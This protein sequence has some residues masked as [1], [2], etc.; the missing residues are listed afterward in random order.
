MTTNDPDRAPF[1]PIS[2]PHGALDMLDRWRQGH[3]LESV[4]L[5]S[6][7]PT[8][9]YLWPHA[10]TV[11]SLSS[12]DILAEGP[13]SVRHAMV[14]SQGCDLVKPT[15]PLATV[16][17]VYDG[18]ATLNPAQQS[19]ARAGSTWHLVHL[20][21]EWAR[22]GFWVADLRIEMS[23]DKS[24]LLRGNPVEGFADGADYAILAERLAAVRMRPA[25]PDPTIDWV[26]KPLQEGLRSARSAGTEM[27]DGVREVRLQSN[28]PT[29]PTVVTVYVVTDDDELQAEQ[30]WTE[31]VLSLSGP[32]DGAGLTVV[33]PEFGTLWDITAADYL[34]SQA[35]ESGLSS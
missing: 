24:L 26:M 23:V 10:R 3:I 31:L 25:M 35:M 12:V 5:V 33:G 27:L 7:G 29:A 17:A 30:N 20:T 4:D 9:G 8:S 15:F 11:A 21:A 14:L 16:A 18:Q 6:A 34:T 22:S 28:D 32:A 19:A 13:S 1:T 2:W